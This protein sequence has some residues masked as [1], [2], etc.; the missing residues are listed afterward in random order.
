MQTPNIITIAFIAILMMLAYL[1]SMVTK[2]MDEIRDLRA[3][4]LNVHEETHT[5]LT[6]PDTSIEHIARLVLKEIKETH[7]DVK[8]ES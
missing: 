6:I 5:E 1:V 4:G 3:N 8:E 2:L 7:G